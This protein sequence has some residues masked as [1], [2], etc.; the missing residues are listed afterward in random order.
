VSSP[1][2]RLL[3]GDT[4]AP[5]LLS[6]TRHSG[7]LAR[8]AGCPSWR[9]VAVAVPLCRLFCGRCAGSVPPF[10]V[11][12]R[13]KR[14]TGKRLDG[15]GPGLE[16]RLAESE[17]GGSRGRL[18]PVG[19]LH[20]ALSVPEQAS[21]LTSA[22]HT[23]L[24]MALLTTAK[25]WGV[26]ERRVSHLRTQIER[27]FEVNK[28]ALVSGH[29]LRPELGAIPVLDQNVADAPVGGWLATGHFVRT[30]PSNINELSQVRI[31]LPRPALSLLMCIA[32]VSPLSFRD[33]AQRWA[34]NPRARSFRIATTGVMDSGLAPSA[35][36]GMTQRAPVPQ[37]SMSTAV[38]L[39]VV[40][41]GRR[42]AP[43][44]ESMTPVCPYH[45]HRGRGFRARALRAPE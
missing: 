29:Q 44:L 41:P 30:A 13:E 8:D 10:R 20:R 15:W 17:F 33:S 1:S 26:G 42:A 18:P 40:I 23:Q 21:S 45:E 43:G 4:A 38:S 5:G 19:I 11:G 16:P 6:L 37:I 25:R 32:E 36:P 22:G 31:L 24:P 2:L 39:S 14:K 12:E 3:D 34:R 35:P 28:T 9:P 7:H 27:Y